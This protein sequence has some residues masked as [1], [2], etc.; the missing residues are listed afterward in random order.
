[1]TKLRGVGQVSITVHNVDRAVKFYRDVLE[2]PFV[3]Q[4]TG[5]AFFMCGDVRLMLSVPEGPEFDHHGSVIYYAVN[6]IQEAYDDLRSK[7]VEF[8]RPP[9]EIGKLG[10]V[11][12]YMAFFHDSENNLLA[13]QAEATE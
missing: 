10:D 6:D 1:M 3:W 8:T 2:L 7:G 4:T 12:V 11:T 13:I 9:H 5:M